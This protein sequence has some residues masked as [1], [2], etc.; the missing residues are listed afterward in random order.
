MKISLL[1][2]SSE[3]TQSTAYEI[4]YAVGYFVGENSNEILFFAGLTLGF[5]FFLILR[6]RKKRLNRGL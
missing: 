2:T 6:K 1:Q 3:M 4:G 5:I